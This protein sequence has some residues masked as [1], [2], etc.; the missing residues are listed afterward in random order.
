[1]ARDRL[2]PCIYYVCANADCQKGFKNVTM[3][4]C[5]NCAKYQGRKSTHRPESIKSKRRKDKDRHDNWKKE[6]Y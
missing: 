6:E 2:N 4:K 1:M 3:A 5:Q